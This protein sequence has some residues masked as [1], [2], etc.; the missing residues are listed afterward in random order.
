MD[1][2]YDNWVTRACQLWLM[3]VWINQFYPNSKVTRAEFGTVLSR[4]LNT[5]DTAKLAQM[6]N[7]EPYYYEHL[8]YLQGE[9]IMNN[10]SNPG[11]LELRWRVML[12]LMR[13][14]K[15]YEPEEVENTNEHRYSVN[16]INTN[17]YLTEWCNWSEKVNEDSDYYDNYRIW[18]S[19]R[20]A[21]IKFVNKALQDVRDNGEYL[22][23]KYIDE[24]NSVLDSAWLTKKDQCRYS[25]LIDELENQR[26][27]IKSYKNENGKIII[28]IDFISHKEN[29]TKDDCYW[30]LQWCDVMKNA[31]TKVRYYTLSDNANL[32]TFN[33]DEDWYVHKNNQWNYCAYI[34]S[35]NIRENSFCN[36]EPIY[37][38]FKYPSE[39]GSYDWWWPERAG[40]NYNRNEWW[41]YCVKDHLVGQ[42]ES[43]RFDAEWNIDQINVN[44][45]E[46]F[47]EYP[48]AS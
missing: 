17:A 31:S 42:L 13:S 9:W 34:S 36:G 32:Q 37:N 6:N 12:M 19:N 45:C 22:V 1:V 4:A 28:G 16:K 48:L 10:I 33:I 30:P 38:W 39:W 11:G 21:D 15:S 3:W 46:W 23:Q 20:S 44:Y 41:I 14:D 18:N 8:K 25:L 7:A 2:Q 47:T 43:F 26:W 35:W 29:V 27:Y 40:Q 24:A 5:K